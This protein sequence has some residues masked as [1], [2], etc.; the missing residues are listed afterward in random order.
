MRHSVVFLLALCSLLLLGQKRAELPVDSR[1]IKASRDS[2]LTQV[3]VTER[4]GK[5]DGEVLKYGRTMGYKSPIYYCAAG[6]YWGYFVSVGPLGLTKTDI[7]YKATPLA[8]DMFNDG[9]RRGRRTPYE[10]HIDDLIFWRKV[11]SVS[12]HVERVV[13]VKSAGWVET[14]G[15]NTGPEAGSGMVDERNGGGVFRRKRNVKHFLGRMQVSGLI[16]VYPK[17]LPTPKPPV[18]AR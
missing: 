11:N 1:L 15:F 6:Q 16:G 4:T 13:A 8:S 10:P 14:V 2:V 12:G 9:Y 5:N 7:P 17:E 3:G 18:K